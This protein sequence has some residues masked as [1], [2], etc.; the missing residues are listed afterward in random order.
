MGV[1]VDTDTGL[2]LDVS[3]LVLFGHPLNEI[4][5]IPIP[6]FVKVVRWW[7]WN[8][9]E[10]SRRCGVLGRRERESCPQGG[11]EGYVREGKRRRPCCLRSD[12]DIIARLMLYLLFV[13]VE[14]EGVPQLYFS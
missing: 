13:L 2:R 6:W 8:S 1:A 12:G 4:Y 3:C 9:Y 7:W 11:R 5:H 14:Q 10:A